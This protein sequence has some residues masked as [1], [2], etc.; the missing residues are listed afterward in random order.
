M[1][2]IKKR[3][4][5]IFLFLLIITP[6]VLGIIPDAEGYLDIFIFAGIYTLITIGLSLLM[7]YA[8]QI[9]L[10]HAAFFGI[11]A[12]VSGILTVNYEWNPWACMVCGIIVCIAVAY[13]IGIPALKLQGHYLAMGTLAFGIVVYIIFSE[14]AALTGGPDGMGGIPGLSLLGFEF[15]TMISYYYLVWTIVIIVFLLS[16][17]LIQ[18]KTG[19][20]L[21]AIHTSQTASSAMGINVPVYKAHIFVYSAVLASI[22]GSLY[23]HYV[24][25]VNPGSFDVSFS[26]LLIIMI[27]VGGMH[28]IWGSVLGALLI[29]FLDLEW[30]EAFHEFEVLAFGAILLATTIFLPE[31]LVSIPN[32]LKQLTGKRKESKS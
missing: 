13:A 6:S 31:G 25:F 1:F 29:T 7:G 18:S 2:R 28:S 5:I 11:G 14:E 16:V 17:N 30:L 4:R 8:G 32:Q 19:R 26:I 10:G 20:A 12:Y 23:A 27:V 3:T 9:S 15:D 24:N 22:A 21:R